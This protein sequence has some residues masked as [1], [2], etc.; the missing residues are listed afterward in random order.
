MKEFNPYKCVS[1]EKNE[2]R[3]A[4]KGVYHADGLKVATDGH[5]LAVIKSEYPDEQEGKIIDKKS[6]V[7]NERFPFYKGAIPSLFK[8]K[9]HSIDLQKFKEAIAEAMVLLKSNPLTCIAITDN[10][11]FEIRYAKLILSFLKI[12]KTKEV[13][14]YTQ[15][16]SNSNS[17]LQ[18][19]SGDSL[20]LCMCITTMPEHT[21]VNNN[22]TK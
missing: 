13:Y 3:P 2:L 16:K 20:L 21:I 10:C 18:V 1:M 22:I 6:C 5:V 11:I 8:S 19:R 14:I 17:I 12:Y 4:H 7:I 9:K 15:K